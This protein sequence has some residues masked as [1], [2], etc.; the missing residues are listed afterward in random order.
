[1]LNTLVGSLLGVVHGLRHALEPDHVVAMSTLIPQQPTIF[2]RLRFALSWGVGHLV[3]QLFVGG[4][5]FLC[6][7]QLPETIEV[8]FEVLVAV[9]LTA[10]GIRALMTAY[11]L[12]GLKEFPPDRNDHV[13]D[14][15]HGRPLRQV[16]A[17]RAFAVG[18][19]HGLQGSGAVPALV[20]ARLP[21]A[22]AGLGF[23]ALYGAGA[24]TGMGLLGFVA[25]WPL[26]RLERLPRA[27]AIIIALAGAS[28]VALG[29][30]WGIPAI[31]RLVRL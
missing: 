29:G 6:R 4:G 28:S 11:E 12:H 25:S 22:A 1:M 13:H 2:G 17:P 9:M 16:V 31:L 23:I 3:I 15:G 5:L 24:M 26:T 21:T 20:M 30:W 7:R 14:H 27:T 19:V 18:L 8:A 10:L